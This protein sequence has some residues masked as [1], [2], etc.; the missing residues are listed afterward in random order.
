LLDRTR[1]V[2][3][4]RLR[5][6]T[7]LRPAR[8]VPLE[9]AEVAT[10]PDT[11]DGTVMIRPEHLALT[12]SAGDVPCRVLRIQLLGGL[13]R[14]TVHSDASP[15]DVLVETTR[16]LPGIAEGGGAYLTI[17]PADAVVYHR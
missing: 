17:P 4:V 5:N 12:A 3:G 10:L 1:P 7:E 13:I 9:S 15:S 6:G 14:Y 16:A 8:V 2:A 11:D